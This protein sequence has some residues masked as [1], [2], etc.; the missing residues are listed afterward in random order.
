MTEP[1]RRLPVPTITTSEI[2]LISIA[3]VL[4]VWMIHSW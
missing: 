3:V 1:A 4:L 2:A